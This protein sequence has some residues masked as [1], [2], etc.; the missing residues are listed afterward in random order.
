MTWISIEIQEHIK[1]SFGKLKEEG[2][3]DNLD[4]KKL[5]GYPYHYRVR[6]GRYRIKMQFEKPDILK[7]HWIGKREN[8]YWLSKI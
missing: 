2:L 6:I 5:I 4:I 8:A 1:D 7:I 3:N